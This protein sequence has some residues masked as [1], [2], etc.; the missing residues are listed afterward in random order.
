[1]APPCLKNAK[2]SSAGLPDALNSHLQAREMVRAAALHPQARERQKVKRK[3]KLMSTGR[4][5]YHRDQ[6]M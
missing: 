2:P 4:L 5:P 3:M 6:M 1:L